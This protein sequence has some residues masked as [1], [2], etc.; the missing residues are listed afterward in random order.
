MMQNR[1]F[2]LVT[3]L[4]LMSFILAAC[5]R[6]AGETTDTGDTDGAADSA[7]TG[8]TVTVEL[9]YHS[10]QGGEREA[11]N[12]SI[13]NFT[14]E[15]PNI[16]I[17]L[18]ELPD[19]SYNDQ[20]NAA[21]LANDLPCLLDFDGPNLYNYAWSGYLIPLDEY[22]DAAGIRDDFLPSILEQGIYNDQ[23]YSL[24]QFDSG[25]GFYAHRTYVE[26]ASLRIPTVEEPWTL[27]E[28]NE[29]L[30]ALQAIE[31][32]EYAFDLKMNYGRGEWF[33]YG[34]SPFVQSF[35]GDLV[36]RADYQSADGV[37]NSSEAVAAMTWFQGLFEQGY[38]NPEPA[39]DTDFVE[40]KTALN[41]VGHWAY[42]DYLD[43]LGDDLLLLPAPDL[44][45]GAVTGMGSW[46]WGITS[47]CENP[48]VAW[49]ILN[50]LLTP[51]EILRMSNANGAVPARLSAIEQSE[52]YGAGGPLNIYVQ[53]LEGGVALPR[54]ITPAYPAI[55]EAFQEAI[56]NIASGADVQDELDKAAQAIDQDIEDNQGYPTQ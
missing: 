51:E 55:T 47:T 53:Q 1:R 32:V 46:N 20:V 5:G 13:E 7:D 40:G 24:G 10:G 50:F 29:A 33:T 56:D 25:L 37:L 11:L 27:D 12:T 22:V 36:N 39:G 30:A 16:T 4:V 8:D 9:W 21:A 2:L 26:E 18:V 54:P 15:N 6:G 31:G 44:G 52:L 45:A 35:G 43:A 38:V 3:L 28:L 41:W 49:E 34:F 17:D 14:S 23:L 19:G 48:D 42:P